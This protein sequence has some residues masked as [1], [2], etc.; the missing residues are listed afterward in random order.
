M[1]GIECV[2]I[3]AARA[4]QRDPHFHSAQDS[5]EYLPSYVLSPLGYNFVINFGLH[6]VRSVKA[7]KLRLSAAARV[8]GPTLYACMPNMMPK[9]K[10][11][12]PRHATRFGNLTHTYILAHTT[13]LRTSTIYKTRGI[14]LV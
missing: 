1:V 14:L 5:R 2:N 11:C 6:W 8:D 9:C 3:V 13:T 4:R 12:R 7:Q 10:K